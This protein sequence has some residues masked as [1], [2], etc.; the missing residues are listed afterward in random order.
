M[1]QI[2]DP[3]ESFGPSWSTP[4]A[5]AEVGPWGWA[6]LDD[7][8]EIAYVVDP[9][10]LHLTNGEP[11]FARLTYADAL[12]VAAREHAQLIWPEMVAELQAR[13]AIAVPPVTLP[14]A[15]IRSSARGVLA[16]RD[17]ESYDA[18][19]LRLRN[20]GMLTESWA[21]HHD[22]EFWRRLGAWPVGQLVAGAG[23]HWVAGAPAN[24]AWLMGWWQGRYFI[25]PFP[26]FD[27]HGFH[28]ASHH[29]YA[30]TTILVRRRDG[31]PMPE[32][33][34]LP[35]PLS[36]VR[37][38]SASSAAAVVGLLTGGALL[39]WYVATHWTEIRRSLQT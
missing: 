33:G 34:T 9:R 3:T 21:R 5:A 4:A 31:R 17:G 12:G 39:A 16:R 1:S 20:A 19:D 28:D 23:K 13:A 27:S 24:R 15:A 32:R 7:D 18:W 36:T 30:T 6:P 35:A 11:L 38:S 8:Y 10:L 25:Q 22:E 2:V 29:D 14:D 37:G 26:A